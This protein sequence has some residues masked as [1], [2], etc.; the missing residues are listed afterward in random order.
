MKEISFSQPTTAPNSG[1]LARYSR[2]NNKEQHLWLEFRKENREKKDNGQEK[3][4]ENM[5]LTKKKKR[6]KKNLTKKKRK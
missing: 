2:S 3:Q 5:R 1:Y 6:E 4:K